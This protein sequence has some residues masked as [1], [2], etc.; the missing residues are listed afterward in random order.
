MAR[1]NT[2]GAPAVAASRLDDVVLVEEEHGSLSR[3]HSMP[4][5]R[6]GVYWLAS[7]ACLLCL[8][9]RGGL[10]RLEW[11]WV[12]SRNRRHDRCGV[13]APGAAAAAKLKTHRHAVCNE[14]LVYAGEALIVCYGVERVL[15]TGTQGSV[16]KRRRPT[17][18][19]SASDAAVPAVVAQA[20]R[21]RR[22]GAANDRAGLSGGI[23]AR[24]NL[25]PWPI[26]LRAATH[27]D[28]EPRAR[29]CPH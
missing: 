1:K 4:I 29:T 13:W 15:Q 12:P 10:M 25:Y 20:R 22:Y 7:P 21:S 9:A 19:W 14:V 17:A 28:E 27:A 23:F 3:T 16:S 26:R 2:Y 24:E 18:A 8:C 11:R 6:N 5:S